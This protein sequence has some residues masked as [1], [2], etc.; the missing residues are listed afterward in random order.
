[1]S[2][3][4]TREEKIRELEYKAYDDWR[5]ESLGPWKPTLS[6]AFLGGIAAGRAFTRDEHDTARTL[7]AEVEAELEKARFIE[8]RE[9]DEVHKVR[10]V[11]YLNALIARADELEAELAAATERKR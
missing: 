5:N 3:A 11:D 4:S 1:M 10:A 8:V 7:L 2:Y 6:D 9:G